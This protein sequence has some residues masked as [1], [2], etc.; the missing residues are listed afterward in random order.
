MGK[1]KLEA[2]KEKKA[3][4]PWN[5]EEMGLLVNAVGRFPGGTM[6]RWEKIQKVVG[7]ER[8]VDEIIA[9]VKELTKK[10]KRKKKEQKQ[11]EKESTADKGDAAAEE[12]WTKE[13]Q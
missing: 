5:E 6:Q 8:S 1:K 9:K 3:G 10:N 11:K 12:V 13:Q 4:K 7:R 2:E